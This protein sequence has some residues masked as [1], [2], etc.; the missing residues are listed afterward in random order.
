MRAPYSKRTN[1]ITH[2]YSYRLLINILKQELCT[3]LTYENNLLVV[4]RHRCHMAA[5]FGELVYEDHSKFPTLYWLPN[6]IKYRSRFIANLSL[7]TTELSITLTSC[8]TA[9]KNHVIR[10]CETVFERI[11]KNLFWSVKNSGEI[12]SKIKSKGFPAS[13]VSK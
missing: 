11:G 4:D 6:F 13:G 1:G 7:C 8:L 10:Y 3:A 9:I 5:K 12:L 2:S